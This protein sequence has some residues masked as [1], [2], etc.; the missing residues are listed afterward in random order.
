M[1]GQ[2]DGYLPARVARR[3]IAKHGAAD[4]LVRADRQRMKHKRRMREDLIRAGTPFLI[5]Y[6]DIV[7]LAI[8]KVSR[9]VPQPTRSAA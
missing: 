6:W 1:G 3:M 2:D 9:A 7:Y 8:A 4:A 5:I